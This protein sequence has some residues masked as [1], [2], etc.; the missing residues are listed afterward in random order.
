MNTGSKYILAAALSAVLALAAL[1][2]QEVPRTFDARGVVK[3]LPAD[4]KTVVIQHEAISNYMGAMTMPFEVHDTNLLRNLKPGDHI[5]F[6]LNVASKEGWID[7]IILLR[8][9]LLPAAAQPGIELSR[10]TAPLDIGQPLPD[11]H[12]TNELGQ[13]A[14]LSQFKGRVLAFTFFFTSCPY[15]NFCP[16]MT[17]NF[18]EAAALLKEKAGPD[19]RWQLLSISFDPKTDTP[20][21]LRDYAEAAHYDPAHWSFLTGDPEQISELADNF[22]EF[23]SNVGAAISHNLRTVVVDPQGRVRKI[24]EGN[25]WTPGELVDEMLKAS[26]ATP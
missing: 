5:R 17:G 21:R 12:F 6:R 13:D 23:Y 7:N 22:G 20:Q 9:S 8:R 19:A 15:P 18:S 26:A 24:F 10:A 25:T 3:E 4:G 11:Y 2:Q 14:R 1:G 16:R